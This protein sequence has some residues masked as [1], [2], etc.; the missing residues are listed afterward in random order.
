MAHPT[1]DH[2]LL[3]NYQRDFPLAPRP[4]ARIADDL[5]I[6]ETEVLERLAHLRLTGVISRIGAVIRPSTIGASTLAAMRVPEHRME[7]VAAVVSACPEVNHNYERE[8]D[9]NLW[10]VVTAAD[11]Q[12]LT[13][14]LGQIEAETDIPVISL[15]LATSFHID[16][17]FDLK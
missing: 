2:Q 9:I 6:D 13:G 15:P 12:Q 14:V 1:L 7:E 4:Y 5:G 17:G 10:F 16:L 11:E 8:H 3:N